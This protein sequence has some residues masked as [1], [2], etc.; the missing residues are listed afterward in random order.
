MVMSQEIQQETYG[1]QVRANG[2]IIKDFDFREW[3]DTVSASQVFKVTPNT[4]LR[5]IGLGY[6]HA[7]AVTKNGKSG[8][9]GRWLI[10]YTEMEYILKH[11]H[12][13]LESEETYLRLLPKAVYMAQ[14]QGR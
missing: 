12:E 7:T 2:R 8:R 14:L 10:H 5:W 11:G 3:F 6:I 4:I 13:L 1:Q 9:V